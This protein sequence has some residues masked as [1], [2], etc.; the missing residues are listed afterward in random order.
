MYVCACIWIN[1]HTYI[2]YILNR[3]YDTFAVAATQNVPTVPPFTVRE[4]SFTDYSAKGMQRKFI[5]D[6]KTWECFF[7][8]MFKRLPGSTNKFRCIQPCDALH[9]Q[10]IACL[11][12]HFR[13]TVNI[14]NKRFLILILEQIIGKSP[15][16]W[17]KIIIHGNSCIILHVI[18]SSGKRLVPN[19]RTFITWWHHQME[20]FSA[21]HRSPVNSSHRGQWRGALILSLICVRKNGWVNNGEAGDL[22]RHRAHYDVIIMYELMMT[23]LAN[24]YH[25]LYWIY[26]RNT[27]IPI[28][29]I[30]YS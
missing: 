6:R 30:K 29:Y 20:T 4:G 14:P 9:L 1:A 27:N 13:L 3:Y 16:S 8:T 10:N 15:H 7:L 23:Q 25:R 21:L 17:P 24:S 12:D 5:K 28:Y 11:C 22:R 26:T 2:W 19:K 18:N